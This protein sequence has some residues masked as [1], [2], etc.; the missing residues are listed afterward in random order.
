MKYKYC[1]L[2]FL[3]AF[4]G[5]LI[6]GCAH[7]NQKNTATNNSLETTIVKALFDYI[8][9]RPEVYGAKFVVYV[10]CGITNWDGNIAPH[11]KNFKPAPSNWMATLS[12][13][14]INV[15]DVKDATYSND[16]RSVVD[17]ETG[18]PG[19]IFEVDKID[20]IS[21]SEVNIDAQCYSGFLNAIGG[22]Y[23]LR[24]V[25]GKWMVVRIENGWA[26]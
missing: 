20:Y 25:K 9:D 13:S 19:V 3:A 14:K 17:K 18:C 22:R 6:C 5:L 1:L 10:S 15:K 26:Q 2:L 23:V 24:N 21:S 4:V 7:L 16:S 8:F 11:I 12:R